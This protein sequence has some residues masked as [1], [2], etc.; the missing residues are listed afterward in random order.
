MMNM[1]ELQDLCLKLYIK[2]D[3]YILKGLDVPSSLV[4]NIIEA[5]RSLGRKILGFFKLRVPQQLEFKKDSSLRIVLD[6][7]NGTLKQLGIMDPI[8]SSDKA[9]A[10]VEKGRSGVQ[11]FAYGDVIVISSKED[12][13]TLSQIVKYICENLDKKNIKELGEKL[14]VK[15]N[16][17]RQDRRELIPTVLE[18]M[19]FYFAIEFKDSSTRK[20]FPAKLMADSKGFYHPVICTLEEA[21]EG[22]VENIDKKNIEV[23][24]TKVYD[25]FGNVVVSPD[26]TRKIL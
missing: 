10:I 5:E 21:I 17:K 4:D 24:N 22:I 6:Y 23:F 11:H 25:Q 8:E 15:P 3:N 26:I 20:I 13:A 14:G 7:K 18:L 1:F 19:P 2:R 16:A 12:C 9:F